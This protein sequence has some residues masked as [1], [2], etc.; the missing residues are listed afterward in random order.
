MEWAIDQQP[1]LQGYMAVEALWLYRTNKNVLGGGQASLTGPS[2]V[3]ETNIDSV[4]ELA[5]A[6]TR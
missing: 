2:F 1:F 6:G 3:D 5:E 4:A